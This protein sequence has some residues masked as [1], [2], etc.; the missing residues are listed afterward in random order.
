M[1]F[2]P[3]GTDNDKNQVYGLPSIRTGVY[4]ARAAQTEVG[5]GDGVDRAPADRQA[6]SGGERI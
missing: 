5:G 4:S 3:R 2:M 6:G 1:S